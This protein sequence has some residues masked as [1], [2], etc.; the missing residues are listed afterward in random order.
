[1]QE[2][3]TN[4]SLE[5]FMARVPPALPDSE[6]EGLRGFQSAPTAGT[7]ITQGTVTVLTSSA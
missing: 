4:R 5:L 3:K 6:P 2:D 1:M 7:M